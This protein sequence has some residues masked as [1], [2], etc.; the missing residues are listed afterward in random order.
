M[1]TPKQTRHK[2]KELW[3]AD[4]PTYMYWFCFE[5]LPTTP[6]PVDNCLFVYYEEYILMA[7]D[8]PKAKDRKEKGAEIRKWAKQQHRLHKTAGVPV[9]DTVILT[10]KK[11]KNIITRTMRRLRSR[12]MT[13]T[14]IARRY[15]VSEANV[16]Y[17]VYVKK[18]KK[19]V[20]T[21]TV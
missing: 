12:G 19:S 14:Q 3:G 7:L 15:G 5:K 13:V 17:H 16:R 11:R 10:Y 6:P 9:K 18:L 1:L 20:D 2:F 4:A 8:V 21:E